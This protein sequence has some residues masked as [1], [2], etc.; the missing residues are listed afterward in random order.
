MTLHVLLLE[1]LEKNPEILFKKDGPNFSELT[2]LQENML[3]KASTLLNKNGYIIYMV[4]SFLKIETVDQVDKFLKKN[5]NFIKA[6][7]K[8]IENKDNY[9][10][11]IKNNCMITIPNIILNYNIDGYFAAYLKKIK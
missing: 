10:K 9:L 4:C 7:F 6:D 5:L 8:L 3:S 11:L 2:S 1:Q